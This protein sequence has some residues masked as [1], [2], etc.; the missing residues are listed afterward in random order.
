MFLLSALALLLSEIGIAAPDEP[1]TCI[2]LSGGGDAC[3]NKPDF[4]HDVDRAFIALPKW[5]HVRLVSDGNTN[6]HNSFRTDPEGHPLRDQIGRV[7]LEHRRPLVAVSGPA[8]LKELQERILSLKPGEP[9][10]LYLTDHGGH[11]TKDGSY[12]IALWG[13]T[14]TDTDLRAL[15]DK[16]PS[17]S[18]VITIHDH[19]FGGGML[20]K[21][22]FD[23]KGLPRPGACGFAASESTEFSY[24]GQTFM[25]TAECMFM[26]EKA[27]PSCKDFLSS[28][29]KKDANED[30]YY[31]FSE[32]FRQLQESGK[33]FSSP[34]SSSDLYLKYRFEKKNTAYLEASQ[35]T[36]LNH[37]L[38]SDSGMN[39][40]LKIA[41]GAFAEPVKHLFEEKLKSLKNNI[42]E[43]Y[44]RA[45]KNPDTSLKKLQTDLSDAETEIGRLEIELNESEEALLP[46]K[47]AFMSKILGDKKFQELSNLLKKVDTISMTLSLSETL[48]PST[49]HHLEEEL[50][51]IKEGLRPL[52]EEFNRTFYAASPSNE[53]FIEFVKS[54]SLKNDPLAKKWPYITERAEKKLIGFANA[55][56]KLK[57]MRQLM[58]S[59]RN[60][61]TLQSMLDSK[62]SEGMTTYLGLMECEETVMSQV[63]KK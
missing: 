25:K 23:N 36:L 54:K 10:V 5:K 40:F 19:C 48:K 55:N 11:S 22:L 12:S 7:L 51:R 24:S 60:V 30:G 35:K 61:A 9:V 16:I 28:N 29:Q 47:R 26:S 56:I 59:T 42:I 50:N 21:S 2:T 15:L 37:C 53:K 20:E 62:D 18:K 52:S 38:F 43:D 41:N 33:T 3:N 14:L 57:A 34:V 1:G 45:D 27:D 44:K 13:E 32:V 8:H 63:P 31:S 4:F 58:R 6:Q 46:A 17:T 49:R 39:S